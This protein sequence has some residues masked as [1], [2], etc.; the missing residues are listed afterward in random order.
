MILGITGGVGAGKTTVLTYL[1]QRYGARILELDRVA[2]KLQKPGAAC[3]EDM[4]KLLR[5]YTETAG[6]KG[7]LLQKDGSF[8]RSAVA[9]LVFADR[10][11]LEKLNGI[12][13]PAVRR[14]VAEQV[15]NSAPGELTVIEAALLLEERYDEICDEIWYIYADE[16]TRRRRLKSSRGYSDERITSMIQS[17]RSDDSFRALCALAIDNSSENVQNTFWQLDRALALRDIRKIS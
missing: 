3:Y 5:T 9:A 12:I 1:A 4:L 15:K 13:H 16:D 2:E 11:L 10:A 8:D 6:M 14:Y 7:Q 17:Q